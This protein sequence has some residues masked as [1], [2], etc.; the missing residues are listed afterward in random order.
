MFI[1]VDESDENT[2]RRYRVQTVKEGNDGTFEVVAILYVER[3]F[4]FIDDGDLLDHSAGISYGSK[5]T[6]KSD[7]PKI[8]RKS[9]KFT[10][11]NAT[12]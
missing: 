10:V 9:I 3:K 12:P 5:T 2:F 7:S 6:L 8:K 11:N 1:L 4:D